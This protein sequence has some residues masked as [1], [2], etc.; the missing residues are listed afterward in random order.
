MVSDLH[1]HS[2]ASDGELTP[3]QVVERAKGKGIEC[4]ALSDHDTAAGVEQAQAAGRRL[5][6][7]VL[8]AIELSAAFAGELHI[9]G[10]GLDIR[11]A[12][13]CAFTRQQQLRRAQRN[14]RMVEALQ[15]A[16]LGITEAACR[17]LAPGAGENWGRSHMARALV[18]KGCCAD[19]KEAFDR[20][21]GYGKSCYV[22][23]EK[24]PPAECIGLIHRCGGLAVLAHP[25]LIQVPEH[26]L[27][28]LIHGLQAQGLDGLEAYYPQH[29]PKEAA[30]Y[31]RIAR[32]LG[33]YVTYGSDFHGPSRAGNE[34]LAG[35]LTH[36]PEGDVAAF[37][38]RL[39]EEKEKGN[40]HSFK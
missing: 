38:D 34:M 14:R 2:T 17:R 3:E 25:G 26:Q 37:L 18:E 8:P 24:T 21:L 31:V 7:T 30:Q 4:I 6:V 36:R 13:F 10:Y 5:G 33:L 29:S 20:Y 40:A 15:Q 28:A 35:W 39:M 23:R 11:H 32:M 19:T 16:G 12:D 22:P 1:L 9:L 27:F